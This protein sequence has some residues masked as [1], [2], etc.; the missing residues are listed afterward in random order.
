MKKENGK[1]MEKIAGLAEYLKAQGASIVDVDVIPEKGVAAFCL[2]KHWWASGSGGIGMAA[3]IGVYRDGDARSERFTYRDQYDPRRDNWSLAYKKVMVLEVT[4]T[5]VTISASAGEEYG[6]RKLTF[7]IA[8]KPKEAIPK[9]NPVSAEEKA[10]F[11]AEVKAAMERYVESHKISHP[12]FNFPCQIAESKIDYE[13]GI[14]VWIL[15]EMIDTD[16]CT[17]QG[18]GWLGDQYRF[19]VWKMER[20]KKPARIYEDHAYTKERGCEIRSLRLYK[21]K[22]IFTVYNGRD[23]S[24]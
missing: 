15:S 18:S 6:E 13:A 17:P 5:F 1:E 19:S 11:E 20:G 10:A 12:L 9:A 2:D 14:A 8:G 3:I 21:G 4:D 7:D 22:I 24:V 23:I 16:R